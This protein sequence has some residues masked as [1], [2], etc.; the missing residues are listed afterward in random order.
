VTAHR[1]R[2]PRGLEAGPPPPAHVAATGF[3]WPAVLLLAAA[4]FVAYGPA[5]RGLPVWDDAAHLTRP[6]LRSLEGLRRIWLEPGATQQYYPLTHSAFWVQQ[7]LWGDD[8]L[9]YHLVNVS[10]HL[11][12]ALVL[13]VVLRS[14]RV[15]GALLAAAVFALHPVHV[16]SVA[17]ITELK[18]TLSGAFFA[19]ATLAYLRFDATRRRGAWAL[20][21]LLFA[22]GLLAKSVVAV[23]PATLLALLWWRNG[24][25][26]FRRDVAPLAPLFG[27]GLAAGLL[28]AWVERRYVIGGLA[29]HFGL[30]PLERVLLAGRAVWF[31]LGALLWPADLSFFYPRWEISRASPAAFLYPFAAALLAIGLWALRRHG[32]GPLATYLFFVLALVP[33][34]GFV[35]VYPF[36]FS[37]VA[38]H[39][40]YLA[41]LGPIVLAAAAAAAWREQ[42]SGPLRTAGTAAA[43]V[44]LATLG[45]LTWRQSRLYASAE[46]LYR[47]TLETNPGAWLALNN[48]GVLCLERGEDAEAERLFFEALRWNPG[49][50]GALNN[51]GY[52]LARRGAVEEAVGYYRRALA[53]WPDYPDANV[54]LG[55]ALFA[56]GRFEEAISCY[57]LALAQ[58]PDLLEPRNNLA[59]ALVAAGRP[60][61]A[62]PHFEAALERDGSARTVLVGLARTLAVSASP[63]VRDGRRA[64][65][66]AEKAARLTA[67][68]D[69]AVLD[70]LA[71]SYAEAG[72]F[73]DAVTMGEAALERA[74]QGAG[75]PPPA[76]IE[77][78]LDL[79]RAGRPFHEASP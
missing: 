4:T 53:I 49:Y 68:R 35:D 41:S 20:A 60:S 75:G 72:R 31:Y 52:V 5:W 67:W 50:E 47:G 39:F 32:R 3:P 77:A 8:T 1:R 19:F 70:V 66:L 71:A 63:R 43:I 28:T 51:C 58:R 40:Q 6:E 14:L 7:K 48:L 46:S 62:V 34:L 15:K 12:T 64:V 26:S 36:R 55:N 79:Y 23:L 56:G 37:W 24:R 33:A 18:N 44:L 69:P 16:E 27:L 78:R 54:N 45:V 73:A 17:W 10:L 11:V 42:R 74:R 2:G 13:L 22:L 65:E 30:E 76:E 9:G 21:F 38:D 59:F 29:V 25:L 61:E 57:D